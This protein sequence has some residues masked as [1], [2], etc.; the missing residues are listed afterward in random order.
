[1]SA[2]IDTGRGPLGLKGD[3]PVK[4][5]RKP[6]R[7]KARSKTRPSEDGPFVSDDLRKFARGKPCQMRGPYCNGDPETTVLCHDRR[8]AGAGMGQ[9]PHD[10]WAYHGCSACHAH[11]AEASDADL[12]HAVRRTQDAVLKH[13]GTLTP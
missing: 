9:K 8:G 7:K 6:M 10:T 11:E 1:M 5:D 4:A 3:K 13:F 12:K 2:R